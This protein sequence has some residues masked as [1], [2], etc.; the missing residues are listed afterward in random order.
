MLSPANDKFNPQLKEVLMA[1]EKEERE[2]AERDIE[3]ARAKAEAEFLETANVVMP[4]YRFDET[5][6][7]DRECEKPP[8]QL[9]IGL[10]WEK[11]K[12]VLPNESPFNQYDLKRGQSRGASKSV[13]QSLTG[14]VK[15]DE[16][17]QTSTEQI[18]GRFKAVIEV[19]VKTE[20]VT[21]KA[22]KHELIDE[23]VNALGLLA[24]ARGIFDFDLD[25][26][27]LDTIE[28]RKAIE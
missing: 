12:S 19:E 14:N 13:W 3:E 9:F 18:V 17:G 8:V 11:V 21:Y 15:E 20:K 27:K 23:I 1:Q 5:M 24:K 28:G 16:S 10:G 7:I 4:K 22:R 25:V 26:Q 6:Q 2:K